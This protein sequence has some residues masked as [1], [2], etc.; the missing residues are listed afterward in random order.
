MN[1]AGLVGKRFDQVPFVAKDILEHNYFAVGFN[2]R[3]FQK[4]NPGLFEPGIIMVKII[5]FQNEKNP[6]ARLV[7]DCL[8]LFL[9][10]SLGEDKS[11]FAASRRSDNDPTLGIGERRVLDKPEPKPADVVGD[12][13]IVVRNQQSYRGDILLHGFRK[14]HILLA[15]T[16]KIWVILHAIVVISI[17][18]P[19]HVSRRSAG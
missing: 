6:S 11:G 18:K 14:Y 16:G 3:S 5:G 2:A 8:P 19:V 4:L 12:G 13:L 9:R 10:I 7:A 17:Q 1:L 15:L